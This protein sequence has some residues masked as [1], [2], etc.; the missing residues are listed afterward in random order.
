MQFN[1]NIFR[2]QKAELENVLDQHK[3]DIATI[4]ETKLE[5]AHKTH[6]STTT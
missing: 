5:K 3:L 6:N 1:V 2:K 4:Q